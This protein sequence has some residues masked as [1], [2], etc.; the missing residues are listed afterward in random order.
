MDED[1]FWQL[2][3]QVDDED[4]AGNGRITSAL[5]PRLARLP[6]PQ[7]ADFHT[8]LVQQCDRLLTWEL[9]EAA[10]IILR[11]P[12]S[13]D[14][15]QDFRPWIVAQGRQTFEAALDDPDLLAEHPKVVRLA[16]LAPGTLSNADFPHAEELIG[17]AEAAFECV[18]AKLKPEYAALAERPDA[19]DLRPYGYPDAAPPSKVGEDQRRRKHYPSLVELFS[20]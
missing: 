20:R 10:E 5:A 15:F 2:I 18:L 19:F 9:W 7:L 8:L 12:V 14:S 17:V 13:E 11:S 1:G 16:G 4:R 6:V 3:E